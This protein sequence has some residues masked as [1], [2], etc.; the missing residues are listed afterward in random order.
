LIISAYHKIDDILKIPNYLK[1]LIPEYKFRFLNLR[2]SHPVA[3][4]VIIAY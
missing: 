3:D 2:R 1:D 4:K